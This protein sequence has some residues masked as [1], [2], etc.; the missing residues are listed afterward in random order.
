MNRTTTLLLCALLMA[1]ITLD[2]Y[3]RGQRS[4]RAEHL[5]ARI[6]TITRTV[7]RLDTIY[8]DSVRVAERTRVRWDT[9]V[10]R[11]TIRINDTLYVPLAPA[12]EAIT[13][14]TAALRSCARAGA[15]KD[16]LIAL[17]GEQ[18]AAAQRVDV[19]RTLLTHSA[20]ALV[21]ALVMAIVLR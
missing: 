10:L 13:A 19:G 4:A 1:G 8:R 17:Q 2:A 5:A 20:V 9:V 15:A 6:D 14:C 18:I 16:T 3:Q 21:A 7:E 11:D 12:Q